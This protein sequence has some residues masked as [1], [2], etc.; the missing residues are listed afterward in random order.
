LKSVERES[1]REQIED[2][3][4]KKREPNGNFRNTENLRNQLNGLH[5]SDRRKPK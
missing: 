4:W 1:L 5:G 3:K 2:I